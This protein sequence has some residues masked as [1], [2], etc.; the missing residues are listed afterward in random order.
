MFKLEKILLV[1][2]LLLLIIYFITLDVNSI[3][4]KSTKINNKCNCGC[5][6]SMIHFND[7]ISYKPDCCPSQITSSNGCMC[8]TPK[9]QSILELRGNNNI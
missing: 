2:F 5:G 4:Y 9:I 6:I 1:I 8:V 3:E 7:L